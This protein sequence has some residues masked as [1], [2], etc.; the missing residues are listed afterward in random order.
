MSEK[1]EVHEEEAYAEG[2]TWR[3]ITAIVYS[4]IVMFPIAIYLN[5]VMGIQLSGA[6]SFITAI[7]FVTLT[8]IFGEKRLTTQETFIVYLIAGGMAGWV[9]TF[10]PFMDFIR[11]N[12]VMTSSI[13]TGF[14]DP[15]TGKPWPDV[16]PWW[17]GPPKGSYVYT[18]RGFEYFFNSAWLT[19]FI[20]MVVFTG[21]F[22]L[23]EIALTFISVR[24]FIEVEELPFP[25]AKLDA[26]TITTISEGEWSKMKIFALSSLVGIIWGLILYGLPTISLGVF[27]IPLSIIP[28]PWI[29]LNPVIE[30]I[31]PGAMLAVTADIATVSVGFFIP[32]YIVYGWFVSSIGVWVFG[33]WL[34]NTYL[35]NI[36][37]RWPVEW[38]PGM[39]YTLALQ[40]SQL[41]VWF[42]PNIGFTLA[43]IPIIVL[44]FLKILRKST[45]QSRS[46]KTAKSMSLW[47][48]LLMYLSGVFI[49][50]G[51][52]HYFVPDF[53]LWIPLIISGGWSLLYSLANTRIL[54][55]TGASISSPNIW[56]MSILSSGYRQIDV[57]YAPFYQ[58]G[59]SA[60]WWCQAV[61]TAHL[62]KTK[63]MSYFKALGLMVVITFVLS[64]LYIN[65][66]WIMAPIPSSV[67]P[68]TAIRWPLDVMMEGLW[69][70]RQLAVLRMDL[71]LDGFILM[72]IIAAII[73]AACKIAKRG[74]FIPL[75]LAIISGAFM[76]PHFTIPFFIGALLSEFLFPKVFGREWW[77][78]NK[79]LVAAGIAAGEGVTVGVCA[80]ITLIAKSIWLL[81]Y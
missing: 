14:T 57:W 50:I 6:A 49:S 31:L 25:L 78:S 66:F 65:L 36:F 5:L 52:F 1:E 24:M 74:S 9:G 26:V 2:L 68:S 47:L 27:N 22:Y 10:S 18:L 19:P 56:G 34:A 60:L 61:K 70:T 35:S 4:A 30:L 59:S 3:S 21:I 71:I 12:Y 28:L 41:W 7:L 20:L 38:T 54:G 76:G 51:I 37:P 43:V 44:G 13:P 46:V 77:G 53:P 11:K 29:D 17:W 32:V 69:V 45:M 8:R 16:L 55:E 15:Y 39:S 23:C 33:N 79:M 81:P 48:L 58:G 73:W 75:S 63:P 62:T 80:L 72:L 42:S 67:Y 40:R 64:F